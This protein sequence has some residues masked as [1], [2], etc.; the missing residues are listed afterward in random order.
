MEKL[1]VPVVAQQVMNP[2]SILRTIQNH[3][4]PRSVSEGSGVVGSRGVVCRCGSDLVL[5]WLW[6][7]QAAAP[8][9]RPLA[10]EPPHGFRCG[11]KKKKYLYYFDFIG[12]QIALTRVEEKERVELSLLKDK[13]SCPLK[14]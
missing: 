4:W 1:G 13:Q 14:G 9:I 5:L 7:R 2:T 12:Q 3:P 8:R 6:C 11:P 10:W